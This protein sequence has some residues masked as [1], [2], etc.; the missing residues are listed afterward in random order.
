M[1]I[2][3]IVALIII[4]LF[5]KWMKPDFLQFKKTLKEKPEGLLDVDDRYNVT[6]AEKEQEL[7]RLLEKINNEGIQ[8]LSTEERKRLEELSR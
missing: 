4:F 6:K 7:N 3:L 1:P 8:K 5:V 2:A